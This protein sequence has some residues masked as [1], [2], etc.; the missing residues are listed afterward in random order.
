VAVTRG[1]DGDV[2]RAASEHFAESTRIR[3]R[4]ADLLG[5]EIHPDPSHREHLHSAIILGVRMKSGLIGC[6][7]AFTVSGCGGTTTL[8]TPS[9]AVQRNVAGRFAAAV[10]QGDDLGA[11]A[12]L[13]HSDDEALAAL[14]QWAAAPWGA[15]PASIRLPARHAGNRWTFSYVGRSPQKDGVFE[16]HSGDLV[17]IVAPL[18][19]G[20]GV[21]FFIVTHVTSFSTHHDSQLS[22][23]K[24]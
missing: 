16:T 4:H 9:Q 19:A 24:R 1:C 7:V 14:V 5:V 10:L 23:S 20:A 3:Q 13:V 8:K 11:R 22:P 2:R 17:V 21:Q 15:H 18:A 12:L 6:L